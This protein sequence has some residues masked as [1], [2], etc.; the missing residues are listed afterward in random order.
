MYDYYEAVK[1][2]V[3]KYIKEEVDMNGMDL[4][5]LKERL[6]EELINEDSV[7]GNYSGSYTFCRSE[8]QKYVEENKDLVREMCDEFGG[9]QRIANWW[10][11]DDYESI[12]VSIRCYVLGNAIEMAIRSLANRFEIYRNYGV[13]GH[14]K[15]PVYTYKGEHCFA[16]TSDKI[17]VELPE[18]EYFSFYESVT[19]EQMV[20][21]SWGMKYEI[22]ELLDG[23]EKPYFKA[24][25]R[26]RRPH[27]VYLEEVATE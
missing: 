9:H 12:D 21:S 18:N 7:T 10:L 8:A 15:T 19:G 3:L 17:T 2:D 14:E 4:D 16:I 1:D 26:E 25:D 6:Y 27:K 11:I 24:C 20:E 5:E 13:L 23:K 22:D